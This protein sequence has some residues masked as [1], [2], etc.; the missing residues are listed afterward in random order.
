MPREI[1]KRDK[2]WKKG[3][4]E[5][6]RRLAKL[7]ARKPTKLTKLTN[8]KEETTSICPKEKKGRWKKKQKKQKKSQEASVGM[9][10]GQR[11]KERPTGLRWWQY[12]GSRRRD[13]GWRGGW[14]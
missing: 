13:G 4:E 9:R 6:R 1:G 10:R 5:A 2:Q 7:P 11:R 3:R 8:N 14:G 12:R